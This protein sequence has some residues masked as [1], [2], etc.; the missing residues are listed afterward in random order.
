MLLQPRPIGTI[1]KALTPLTRT[2][3]GR[4]SFKE[5]SYIFICGLFND[6]ISRSS[7]TA[8]NNRMIS[9]NW[10]KVYVKVN[11]HDLIWGTSLLSPGGTEK[12]AKASV[13]KAGLLTEIWKQ[14]FLRR[15]C[16]AHSTVTFGKHKLND[17]YKL[18]VF[19]LFLIISGTSNYICK[20]C[21]FAYS[22]R[23]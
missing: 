1:F 15:K 4:F 23:V 22:I 8:S 3:Q 10:I 9:K 5:D 18:L 14:D 6:N 19:G 2:S 17:T 12:A 11:N 16:S 20:I 13:R 7:C 21:K